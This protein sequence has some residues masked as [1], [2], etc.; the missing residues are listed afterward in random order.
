MRCTCRAPALYQDIS[1]GHHYGYGRFNEFLLA[2]LVHSSLI[3]GFVFALSNGSLILPSG[4]DTGLWVQGLI[5]ASCVVV[6]VNVKALMISNSWTVLTAVS[7]ALSVLGFFLANVLYNY[8]YSLEPNMYYV[9]Y[10]ASES[11]AYF[12]TVLLAMV[13][14]FA[15]DLIIE[16]L[17]AIICPSM[18]QLIAESGLPRNLV[19]PDSSSSATFS[20]ASYMSVG[21]TPLQSRAKGKASAVSHSDFG[22]TSGGSTYVPH[23]QPQRSSSFSRQLSTNTLLVRPADPRN[24]DDAER[25]SPPPALVKKM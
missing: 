10:K 3:Y 2:A 25:S 24:D 16:G 23:R 11:P 18:L 15:I 8:L 6:V 1:D 14:C 19:A 13:T 9:Y 4:Q 12:F 22:S 5:A 7:F 20:A 21:F 17:R